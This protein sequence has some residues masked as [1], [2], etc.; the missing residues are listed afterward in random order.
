MKRGSEFSEDV[1]AYDLILKD[2]ERLLSFEEPCRFIFSH[3]ALREGW[4]NPNVFQ[5]CTLKSSGDS[6]I[7]KRQEVGRGL[8]LCVNQDGTR[9]DEAFLGRDGVHA[10]NLLTVIASEGYD[11]F[12]KSLQSETKDELRTRPKKVD[13]S[14]FARCRW[15]KDG[16]NEYTLT[17]ADAEQDRLCAASRTGSSVADGMP[18]WRNQ[19]TSSLCHS[20]LG[21]A[22][23]FVRLRERHCTHCEQRRRL[24]GR[25]SLRQRLR[26]QGTEQQTQRQ[27]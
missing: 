17:K 23:A 5:I 16:V 12:V 10:V 20:R 13:V 11:S 8:R 22:R 7:S 25:G 14:L 18:V 26:H 9:Q 21:Y 24:R 6:D 19:R 15:C 4:D 27:L 1:S 2:K 3:S